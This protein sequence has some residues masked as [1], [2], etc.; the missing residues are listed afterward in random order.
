MSEETLFAAVLERSPA[1]R[2]RFLEEA[3]GA[4]PELLQRLKVL[5][6]AHEKAV[7]ILD[8]PAPP[9]ESPEETD[10]YVPA[11][12]QVG[13]LIGGRY[14]LLEQIG[15]GGMGTVWVA[16]QTQPV[17]RKVA[18]KLIKAGMDSKT[19]LSRFEAE[20]QALA[21]MDHPNIAKVLDGG[22]TAA[23]RPF[24]VM[25]YV[26]GVSFTKYCDDARLSIAERLMLFV[27][28][29]QAVQHAHQ[30]GIIHRDLKPS[31]ILVC[32]YDGQPVP[33]VIDFGLAKAMHQSLTEHTLYTAHGV[34]MGTPPYMSPEQAEFNNLDVDTRTDIYALGV[35]LYEL[36]TGTT[37]LEKK[38][39]KEAALHEMLRLIK[40]EEPPRPSARLSGSGSL[41]SVAAQRGLEPV[42]LTRVVRGELDWIVMKCLEKERGRRYETAN[43]LARELQ[44]YLSDEVVEAR[45]PSA[46][47]RLRKFARR[48]KG[49]V[50]AAAALTLAVLAGV[51]TVV[52][53]QAKANRDLASANRQL[54]A[55]N[56]RERQRFALAMEAV[57]LF[58]GNVSKD[59]LLKE[60]QFDGLRNKLLRGAA[61]FY[62]KLEA[63]LKD[64][65]DPA[66]RATL[67]K[68]YHELGELTSRIG[69]KQA[70]LAVYRKALAVRRELADRP[71]A[72]PDVMLDVARTLLEVG[73]GQFEM[74]DFDAATPSCEEAVKVAEQVEAKFGASDASRSVRG[75]ANYGIGNALFSKNRNAE[76]LLAY[77]RARAL[78]QTLVDTHPSD[79]AL[80]R[81]LAESHASVASLLTVDHPAESM[82]EWQ[83][84]HRL[85]RDVAEAHP[86]DLESQAALGKSCINFGSQYRYTGQWA[87]ALELYKTGQAIYQRLTDANPS[88]TDF[89]EKIAFLP[90]MAGEALVKLGR[91]ADAKAAFERSRDLYVRLVETHPK[92]PDF[93]GCL[94]GDYVSLADLARTAGRLDEARALYDRAGAIHEDLA[95]SNPNNPMWSTGLAFYLRRRGLL[96]YA[97]GRFAEAAAANR[98][99]AEIFEPLQNWWHANIFELACCHAMQVLL[100]GKN[101]SGVPA[102]AGPAETDKAMDL[103]RKAVAAGYQD[104]YDFR[105]DAGLESLRQRS[106]FKKLLAELAEKT[107]AHQREK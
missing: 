30:K 56:E 87:E 14:K 68:A 94:A 70:A 16:E 44:R 4:D 35:I 85:F 79:K 59:L 2:S 106:D 71:D 55:A 74:G 32:L 99:A 28:I 80:L 25:E 12:E 45:P 65:D 64:Q 31:N 17:R 81:D 49:R 23:G 83:K 54:E 34:M 73:L 41:P 38:Q 86:S 43:A 22:T 50:V 9:R 62:E 1:E 10:G 13:T 53:V 95:K 91:P 11:G 82:A 76:A 89:Q 93:Q 69:D 77:Q 42:K 39:F 29:C 105:T 88:N 24:F 3:C 57:E 51:G 47:Y 27:P 33:K 60:K 26:K 8:Q 40:E 92:V 90:L 61:N 52:A 48:N 101:G 104:P 6:A 96:E 7:G 21:L 98:R 18:L 102:S 84:S 75:K 100:A 63:L 67:G 78:R 103:L 19:V 5:V 97:A 58:H 107:K 20:R 36:L 72:G 37:P 46:G 15:E 66:S